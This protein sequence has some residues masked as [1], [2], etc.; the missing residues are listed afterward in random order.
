MAKFCTKCG[1]PL[2]EGEIC[3]C[4]VANTNNN[5]NTI[6]RP[7]VNVTNT[8]NPGFS[9]SAPQQRESISINVNQ[10]AS[11]V[12]GF[13]TSLKN[14]IGIGDPLINQGDAF[15]KGKK[16]IP[17]CVKPNDSEVPVKQ[18]QIA[19]LRNRIMGITY[20]KAYGRI[21]V[22]NKRV[23]FRA[24]G[25]CL[26]GRTTLQHEFA[27][28]EISGVET[29]REFVFNF[30]DFIL[31]IIL[32]TIGGA[33]ST[34]ISFPISDNG[35]SVFGA[36]FMSLLFSAL[37]GAVF[38]MVKKKW[39]LKL[40]CLGAGLSPT[41]FFGFNLFA[42]N[43]EFLGVLLSVLALILLVLSLLTL[44]IYSIRPN[45]AL[46]VKTKSASEAIDIRR[47]KFD[48]FGM[49]DKNDHTGYTEIWPEDD[50]EISIRE[51][52]AIINDIQKLGDFA[53][54]KWKR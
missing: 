51:I 6:N 48:I 24:P 2:S 50:A 27:I 47:K 39:M 3:R 10:V 31:G 30:W 53:I 35:R 49:N 21:Q 12:N 41:V 18:Y 19:T 32:L 25:R 45:L 5:V 20:T 15:E 52:G 40:V 1:R 14:R 34:A 23:I 11:N 29:R 22:T 9:A 33:V 26:A 13:W 17:D 44:F 42:R 38:F 43:D 8:T 46:I 7:T 36:F 37:A 54:E 4:S 16:I 28:D